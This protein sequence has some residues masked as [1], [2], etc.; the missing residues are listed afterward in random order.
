MTAEAADEAADEA[1]VRAALEE[2]AD[3]L[4]R[5]PAGL[6]RPRLTSWPAVVRDSAGLL[7]PSA[8]GRTRPAAPTPGAIDRMD[9]ALAWLLA[10]DGEARRLVWARACRVPWRRLAD[11][12]G[13]SHVTLRKI[14]AR[15][16][17][18][19]LRRLAEG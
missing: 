7:G 11:L 18:Q 13:R 5:L 4:R 3:T 9:R 15:G 6:R 14:V 19:I 12:D 2:A 8:E 1:A 10:C 17:D 16:H